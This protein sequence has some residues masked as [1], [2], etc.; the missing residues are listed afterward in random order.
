MQHRRWLVKSLEC[1][2]TQPQGRYLGPLDCWAI[3]CCTN[4]SE[5]LG[6]CWQHSFYGARSKIWLT[7]AYRGFSVRRPRYNLRVVRVGNSQMAIMGTC[8]GA[9]HFCLRAIRR[10]LGL[11]GRRLG[12]VISPRSMLGLDL[13]GAPIGPLSILAKSSNGSTSRVSP[14]MK[15]K[16]R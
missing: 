5:Y 14:L 6:N 7:T 12:P 11:V 16:C 8:A 15:L 13:V 4:V 9:L 3:C 2:D 1:D 10:R